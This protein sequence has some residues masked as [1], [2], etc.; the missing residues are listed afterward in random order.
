MLAKNLAILRFV[1]T[2]MEALNPYPLARERMRMNKTL[3]G[4]DPS[5]FD[6]EKIRGSGETPCCSHDY[7]NPIRKGRAYY[8]CPLCGEDI[9]LVLVLVH[10]QEGK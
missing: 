1:P 3:A 7:A 10:E 8:V 5:P 6:Q 4:S 2:D 9:T